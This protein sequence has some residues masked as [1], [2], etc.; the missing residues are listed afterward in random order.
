[1]IVSVHDAMRLICGD[2][3]TMSVD[4]TKRR[5]RRTPLRHRALAKKIKAA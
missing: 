1:V 5:E 2:L 4:A 3:Y